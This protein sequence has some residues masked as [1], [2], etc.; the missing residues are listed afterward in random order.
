MANKQITLHH[1]GK[2][3]TLEFNRKAI[4]TMER[5]GFIA[6]DISDKP[7]TTLPALFAGAFQMHHRGL[8]RSTI[9]SMLYTVKNK[10]AFIEKLSEMYN[11]PLLTLI[12]EPEEDEGNITWEASW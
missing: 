4:E 6:A 3:Y 9:D 11:E 10:E 12:D 5:Q 1:E 2:T 7:M 8:D